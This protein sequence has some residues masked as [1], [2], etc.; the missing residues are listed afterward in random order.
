MLF[1]F[2]SG[3]RRDLTRHVISPLSR[4][5]STR[6]FKEHAVGRESGEKWMLIWFWPFFPSPAGRPDNNR[7]PVILEFTVIRVNC[8]FVGATLVVARTMAYSF[9]RTARSTA[10]S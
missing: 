8:V 2:A 6:F 7:I 3:T 4:L 9:L 1:L 5:A 10:F